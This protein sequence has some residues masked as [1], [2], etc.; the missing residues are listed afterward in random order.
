M[1][2]LIGTVGVK[3]PSVGAVLWLNQGQ[4]WHESD[5]VII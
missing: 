5:A 3:L 4:K 1:S 2:T